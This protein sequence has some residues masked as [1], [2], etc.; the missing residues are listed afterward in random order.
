M[1]TAADSNYAFVQDQPTSPKKG[2]NERQPGMH[3]AQ[4]GRP[5][6]ATAFLDNP[7]AWL[8]YDR[9]VRLRQALHGCN[10]SYRAYT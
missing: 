4:A 5:Q 3:A 9:K 7:P 6:Q 10:K 8:A 2:S 1:I